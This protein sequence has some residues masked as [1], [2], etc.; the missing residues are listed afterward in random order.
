MTNEPLTVR[1]LALLIGVGEDVV[2]SWVEAG[3]LPYRREEGEAVFDR[4]AIER[5]LEEK[6]EALFGDDF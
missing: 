2:H 5:W 6:A 1:E 3:M 4:V